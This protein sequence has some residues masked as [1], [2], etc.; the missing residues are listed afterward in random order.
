MVVDRL[1]GTFRHTGFCCLPELLNPGDL[2]VCND[3]RVVPARILARKEATGGKVEILL[4]RRHGPGV[5][6]AL[7][8]PSRRLRLGSPFRLVADSGTSRECGPCPPPDGTGLIIEGEVIDRTPAG[9]WLLRFGNEPPLDAVGRMPL[10]PYVKQILPDPERYQTVYSS[11][12]GSVA[13]PTAGLHFTPRLM[14]ELSAVGIA[15]AFLTIHIGL[16]TFR[17]VTVEDPAEHPIHSEWGEIEDRVARRIESARSSG[18][19]IVA[20]GTSSVRL[21]ET[22]SASGRLEPF[23]GSTRLFII[24]GHR[25]Q[26]VD[27]LLTN[28]HLPR[29]SLLMLVSAFASRELILEAYDEAIRERYRFYSFGDAMLIL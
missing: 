16:D 14:A 20:V 22:A 1:R 28:F 13:A 15:T 27:C 25:F 10:P 21:L 9:T 18:G 17:P 7:L 23:C 11:E 4:L 29:T 24:P 6:E 2:L 26:A 5:W 8:K 12:T 19:R 3:S